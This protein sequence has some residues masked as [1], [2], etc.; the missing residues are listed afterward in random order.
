MKW[1][2]GRTSGLA[3]G[4]AKASL[5]V[6]LLQLLYALLPVERCKPILYWVCLLG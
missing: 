6:A 2:V 3:G 4:G 5:T 1:R